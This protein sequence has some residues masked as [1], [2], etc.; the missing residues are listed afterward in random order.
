MVYFSF[1]L[2]L[3]HIKAKMFNISFDLFYQPCWNCTLDCSSLENVIPSVCVPQFQSVFTQCWSLIGLSREELIK[4]YFQHGFSYSEIFEF[5]ATFQGINLT[6]RHLHRLFREQNLFKRYHFTNF[7]DIVEVIEK[8]VLGFGE[9]FGYRTMHQK[10]RMNGVVTDRETV[11]LIIKTLDL[12]G[13]G[14]R[15]SHKLKRRMHTSLGPNFMWHVNSYDKLKSF[16]FP[17]KRFFA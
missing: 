11:R 15:R 9:N 13:V 2:I 12:L 3:H 5:L 8:E 16:G 4:C 14:L 1:M 6:L 17:A 7:N 10:L